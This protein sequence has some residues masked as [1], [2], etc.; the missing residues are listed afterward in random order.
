MTSFEDCKSFEQCTCFKK[1]VPDSSCDKRYKVRDDEMD[2]KCR[3]DRCKFD[4][5]KIYQA[6]DQ[7]FDYKSCLKHCGDCPICGTWKDNGAQNCWHGDNE[8]IV[9]SCIDSKNG[10]SYSY[11][12]I[13]NCIEGRMLTHL[14]PHCLGKLN[15]CHKAEYVTKDYCRFKPN[16]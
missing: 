16:D 5:N 1:C 10:E 3:L 9:S 4:F 11:E 8:S 14:F 15:G 12:S 13:V 6:N 2:E 7:I